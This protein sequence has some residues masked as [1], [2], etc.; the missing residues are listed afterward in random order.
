[1]PPTSPRSFGLTVGSLLLLIGGIRALHLLWDEEASIGLVSLILWS[2][3]GALIALALLRPSL[4]KLPNL[5]WFRFGLLLSR[6]TNPVILFLMYAVCIVPLG[7]VMRRFGYDPLRLK[8]SKDAAT[9]WIDR[10]PSRLE[11]P[12]RHQF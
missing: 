4:L 12:M 6:V 8:R 9:Y 5:L 10:T 7:I 11:E 3:A 1:M 2:I